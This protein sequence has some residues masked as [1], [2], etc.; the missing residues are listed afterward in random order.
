MTEESAGDD[1][2]AVVIGRASSAGLDGSAKSGLGCLG[3]RLTSFGLR[4][5]DL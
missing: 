4:A 5:Q 1:D 2:L 3:L